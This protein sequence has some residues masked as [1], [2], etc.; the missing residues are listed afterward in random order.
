M[1]KAA[2]PE[3][4]LA[5][6]CQAYQPDI[7]INNIQVQSHGS[8]VGNDVFSIYLEAEGG[9]ENAVISESR[10]FLRPEFNKDDIM[11]VYEKIQRFFL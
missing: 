10:S 9:I 6:I 4:A 11:M 1:P 8:V 3:S 2:S 5:Y 7:V